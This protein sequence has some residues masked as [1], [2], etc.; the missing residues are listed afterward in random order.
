MITSVNATSLRTYSKAIGV[1]AL[2]KFPGQKN[3]GLSGQID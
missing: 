3:T 2:R 1:A